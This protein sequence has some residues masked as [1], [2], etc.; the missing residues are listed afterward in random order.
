MQKTFDV[1]IKKTEYGGDE[2]RVCSKRVSKNGTFVNINKNDNS[3]NHSANIVGCD[4]SE[5]LE[6]LGLKD[7]EVIEAKV[8][9]KID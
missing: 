8:T 4:V 6:T 5:F 2:F 3:I 9:F 7:E 1:F